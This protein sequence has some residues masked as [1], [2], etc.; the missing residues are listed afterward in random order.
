[1]AVQ[2]G[3]MRFQYKD[4]TEDVFNESVDC[5]YE[6]WGVN[7]GTGMSIDQYWS[8]CRRFAAAMGFGEETISEW[9]GA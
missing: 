2:I 4:F 5:T 1:M 6:V 7:E 8:M 9:F 3:G